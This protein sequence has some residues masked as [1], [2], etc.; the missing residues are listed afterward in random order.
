MLQ[1]T[2]IQNIFP[3]FFFQMIEDALRKFA[4][5]NFNNEFYPV[6][7]GETENIQP[8]TLVIKTIQPRHGRLTETKVETVILAELA[9]Y[10]KHGEEVDAFHK[11]KIKEEMLS[12]KQ[13]HDTGARYAVFFCYKN[14]VFLAQAEYS[15]ISAD[16]RLKIF[17]Y[18][19]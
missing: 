7:L 13:E 14:I 10:V 5:E 16:F 8:L 17:L 2:V 1:I 12:L 3:D 6:L 9:K 19:S 15:Y 4:Q 18:F 11:S